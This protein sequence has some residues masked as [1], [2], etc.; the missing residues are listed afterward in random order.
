VMR[1]TWPRYG[2]TSHWQ[3]GFRGQWMNRT[4]PP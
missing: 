3:T 2:L 1:R 4:Q